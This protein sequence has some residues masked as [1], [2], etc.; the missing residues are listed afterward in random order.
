MLSISLYLYQEIKKYQENN[1][2]IKKDE[3][4]SQSLAHMKKTKNLNN[5][6]NTQW[7]SENKRTDRVTGQYC[8]SQSRNEMEVSYLVKHY[9]QER[10]NL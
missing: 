3:F 4:N 5:K 1:N 10:Y 9:L 8:K 2:Y 6:S 7:R